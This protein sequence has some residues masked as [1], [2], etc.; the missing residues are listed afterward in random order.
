ML[1]SRSTV[2]PTALATFS[3]VMSLISMAAPDKKRRARKGG[4]AAC[5]VLEGRRLFRLAVQLG[6]RCRRPGDDVV[7]REGVG[8]PCSRVGDVADHVELRVVDRPV[9]GV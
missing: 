8:L 3:V 9:V 6:L 7:V 4:R 5:C 2:P 1:P